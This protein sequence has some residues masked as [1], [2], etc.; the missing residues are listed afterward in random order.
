MS[1]G[2]RSRPAS[3]ERLP[4][5]C[6]AGF[7][8]D[9][10]FRILGPV[11]IEHGGRVFGIGAAAN[12]SGSAPRVPLGSAAV[13]VALL[14]QANRTVGVATLVDL[15]CGDR[16]PKRAETT[17]RTCVSRLRKILPEPVLHTT[18]SG[19]LLQVAADGLDLGRFQ[20]LVGYA[21]QVRDG[22]PAEAAATLGEALALWRGPALADLGHA[23][24]RTIETAHL[25]ELRLAAV[26]DLVDAELRLGHYA[27]LVVELRGLVARH[28]LRERMAAQLMLALHRSGRRAEALAAYRRAHDTLAGELDQEPGPELRRL[29]DHILDDR[30]AL[31]AA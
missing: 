25:E 29:R 13:L 7:V 18:S 16:A 9:V 31:L 15:V 24:I 3:F 23:P 2:I 28:P 8:V 12:G 19:Y 17:I 11:E 5:R 30:P 21:R 10:E 1:G 27:E 20:R 26:E 22:R 14:L 6:P 4:D